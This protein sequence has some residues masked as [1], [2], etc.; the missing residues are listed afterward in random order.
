MA[1]AQLL[2]PWADEWRNYRGI[3]MKNQ[4]SGQCSQEGVGSP[5]FARVVRSPRQAC[6]ARFFPSHIDTHWRRQVMEWNRIVNL[7]GIPE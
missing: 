6:P 7:S 1:L 5:R 3:A 2:Q 4:G